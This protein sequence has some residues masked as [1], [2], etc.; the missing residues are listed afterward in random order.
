MHGITLLL[1]AAI[2]V[3]VGWKPDENGDL[4]YIIQIAP[5]QLQSLK[6]GD[7]IEVGVRPML[8]SVRRYRIVVGTD[9]LPRETA[10]H[11][12]EDSPFDVEVGEVA[13]AIT[14]GAAANRATDT[15]LLTIPVAPELPMAT[16]PSARDANPLDHSVMVR[17]E[18]RPSNLAD[19]RWVAA[20]GDHQAIQLQ[21]IPTQPIIPSAQPSA[22]AVR[23][24]D[25]LPPPPK[26]SVPPSDHPAAV[27]LSDGR[28]SGDQFVPNYRKQK[29]QSAGDS[30]ALLESYHLG[31]SVPVDQG[32]IQVSGV[33]PPT[34]R[35]ML[36]PPPQ[37]EDSSSATATQLA[38]PLQLPP[39]P[40]QP[41]ATAQP[42][43]ALKT[44]A[45][46]QRMQ[47]T[48]SEKDKDLSD[49][50]QIA[51]KKNTDAPAAANGS[52]SWSVWLA[53]ALF[54]SIG[55]NIFLSYVAWDI[56]KRFLAVFRGTATDGINDKSAEMVVESDDDR[57]ETGS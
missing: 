24:L 1:F 30:T 39:P 57:A 53:M 23:P 48:A 28:L 9:P 31:D 43:S 16:E 2:G 19:P 13:P 46:D 50:P 7:A 42:S 54:A 47:S 14:D 44:A 45:A 32:S 18:E 12:L 10:R 17:P 51:D 33:V 3:D 49:T 25:T 55:G 38:V 41:H 22:T 36:P 15:E 34:P 20:N 5:E 21:P 35:L 37:P 52:S 27:E 26:T 6:S 56:R 40:E 29:Q 4:E 11:A 8:R